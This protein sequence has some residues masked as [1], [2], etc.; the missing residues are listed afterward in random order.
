[1]NIEWRTSLESSC[2]LNSSKI[3]LTLKSSCKLMRRP[4][5]GPQ[6]IG[7]ARAHSKSVQWHRAVHKTQ[8]PKCNPPGKLA[9]AQK[10]QTRRSASDCSAAHQSGRAGAMRAWNKARAGQMPWTRDAKQKRGRGA[11]RHV[12]TR[13]RVGPRTSQARNWLQ[14]RPRHAQ[15]QRAEPQGPT[16]RPR[17]LSPPVRTAV[18]LA[19]VARLALLPGVGTSHPTEPRAPVPTVGPASKSVE[20]TAHRPVKVPLHSGRAG[21]IDRQ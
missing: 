17:H 12:E 13:V 21:F 2:R 1:M 8:Q 14:L 9:G 5:R 3:E 10:P 11:L 15:G 18:E 20:V 6:S 16:A 7:A 4:S 19:K